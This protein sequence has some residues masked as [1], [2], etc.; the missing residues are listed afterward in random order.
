MRRFV[1]ALAFVLGV[2]LVA[3]P[4][5]KA[6]DVTGLAVLG[7]VALALLLSGL[8]WRGA[9]PM[10]LPSVALIGLHY[11][12][13]LHATGAGVDAYALLFAPGLFVLSEAADLAVSLVDLAPTARAA[14]AHRA[15]QTV[16]IAGAGSAV[17][18]VGLV[19]PSL[20]SEGIV[21]VVAGAACVLGVVA[22]P[23]FIARRGDSLET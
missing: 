19:A 17:A 12:L 23:L 10:I 6:G 4:V 14:A 8:A 2:A 1:S 3:Y 11:A 22:L 7:L 15:R 18:A 5:A 13:T 21:L 16:G 9:R 20:S